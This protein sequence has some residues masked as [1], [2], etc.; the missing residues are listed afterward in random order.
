MI[1]SCRLD[2]VG[3]LTLSRLPTILAVVTTP[4]SPREIQRHPFREGEPVLIVDDRGRKHVL[5]LRAGYKTHHGR[6]GLVHHDWILGRP[7]G[8][9]LNGPQ[10]EDYICVR[11][12]LE[13]Y[14]LKVLDRHTQVIYPKDLG[15]LLTRGNLFSGARALEA[16][17]G[18]G[19]AALLFRRFLGSE[20]ELVSYEKREE[21][22]DRTSR[23]LEEFDRLY[24]HSLA[25]HRIEVR[26]VYDG[27]A[28]TDLDAVLLD[29]PEPHRA[30]FFAAEALRP[31]GSLLCWLPTV[32]QVFDLVQHLHAVP[33][34]AEVFVTETL[35]RPWTV[36]PQSIRPS[37]T[38][39]AH[40]GFL[41]SA[42][43]VECVSVESDTTVESPGS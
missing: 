18:S 39:V 13:D 36:S 28:E 27:I 24:G 3:D 9:R 17:L 6:T 25:T 14:V 4:K 10:G 16:G 33:V 5:R 23:M 8:L 26:D 11:P 2:L 20:G 30:T 34:W 31:N 43:R 40:T 19:A 22:A 32:L 29:V 35:M 37:Q 21:F 42:R 1:R 12:T 15:S 41:I 38:M 7:P